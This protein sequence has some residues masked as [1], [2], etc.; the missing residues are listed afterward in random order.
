[1]AGIRRTKGTAADA[2][3]PVMIE[4]LKRMIARLPEDCLESGTGPAS[5]RVRRGLP[6]Q[7]IDR[8]GPGSRGAITRDG[9]VVTIRRSKTDQDGE[10]R[11]VGLPFGPTRRHAR[12]GVFKIGWTPAG[13]RKVRCSG[14]LL[15]MGRWR[16][17][18]FEQGRRQ[19]RKAVRQGNRVG[20]QPFRWTQSPIRA[21]DIGSDGRG[22]SEAAIMKQTG[23]RSLTTVR[24][25]IRDG[26]LFREN[27]AAVLGL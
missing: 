17:T 4:D 18:A 19:N 2:K 3:T 10:G 16:H 14:P 21:G 8:T 7:R 27:A 13:S 20:R 26:S 15:G 22:Q 12:C 6:A 25:Y 5:D 24:R 23:H 11:K 1:M 9:L